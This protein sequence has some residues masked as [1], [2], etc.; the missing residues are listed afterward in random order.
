MDRPGWGLSSPIDYGS[1]AFDAL[2]ASMLAKALDAM[3][4][5][6]VDLVGAS[7][8]GLWALHL[9]RRHPSR[10][11]RVVL[12]GGM[13]DSEIGVPT[14]IKLLTS[15]LGAV[16]V[17]A[18]MTARML[19]SQLEAIGH[20]RS[21][22]AGRMDDFIA[23]RLAFTNLTPSMRHERSM[24][25]ALRTG[26]RWRPAFTMENTDLEQVPHPVRMIFGSEDPTGSLELWERYI[27]HLPNGEVVVVPGAGHQ[28]WWD[29]PTEVGALTASFL[30]SSDARPDATMRRRTS[31]PSP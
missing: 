10:V 25:R 24:A 16:M 11:G 6:R 4:L 31:T 23:W 29:E 27:R 5:D 17:R 20:G 28:P 3:E 19:R 18:P 21:V 9:A 7:I 1:G 14:F 2:A 22:A 12:L 13:P 30:T 15:P 8:G 26:A